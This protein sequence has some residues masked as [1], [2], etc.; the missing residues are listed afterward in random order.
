MTAL[1]GRL[2][3]IGHLLWR[4]RPPGYRRQPHDGGG[5]TF[6]QGADVAPFRDPTAAANSALARMLKT[7]GWSA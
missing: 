5:V 4:R 2:R 7:Q 3:P 6:Y 1:V